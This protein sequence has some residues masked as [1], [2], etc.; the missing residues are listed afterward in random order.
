MLPLL[1]AWV[2]KPIWNWILRP[3]IGL[4][5]MLLVAAFNVIFLLLPVW[6]LVLVV[7][8]IN[9]IDDRHACWAEIKAAVKNTMLDIYEGWVWLKMKD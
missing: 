9:L 5:W 2:A 3:I 1:R 4:V 7:A 8:I 6:T